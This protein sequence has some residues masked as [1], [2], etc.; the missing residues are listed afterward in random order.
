MSLNSRAHS[1]SHSQLS[2]EIFVR[3]SVQAAQG[4]AACE[5]VL[6]NKQGKFESMKTF[7][8]H[9]YKKEEIHPRL[10]WPARQI[11][12]SA[13]RHQPVSSG[14]VAPLILICS[15]NSVW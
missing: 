13:V 3:I 14:V 1:F 4:R 8:L 5:K 9:A 2:M 10:Y 6:A 12:K 15:H 11:E 7:C